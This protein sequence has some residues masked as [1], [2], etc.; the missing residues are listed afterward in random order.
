MKGVI[1]RGKISMGK[2]CVGKVLLQG[3]CVCV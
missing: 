3:E 1:E 2:E